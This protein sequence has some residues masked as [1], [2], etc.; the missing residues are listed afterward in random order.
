MA[1]DRA[2]GPARPRPADSSP[3]AL[4]MGAFVPTRLP[5][6]IDEVAGFISKASRAMAYWSCTR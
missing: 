3:F 4:F 6:E 2:L 1:L 5:Q